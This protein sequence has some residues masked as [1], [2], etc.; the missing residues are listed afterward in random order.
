MHLRR[1]HAHAHTLVKGRVSNSYLP[2]YQIVSQLLPS[3]GNYQKIGPRERTHANQESASSSLSAWPCPRAR[4][5]STKSSF[6]WVTIVGA[7]ENWLICQGFGR[8]GIR[9]TLTHALMRIRDRGRAVLRRG[10][11][12]LHPIGPRTRTRALKE[13]VSNSFGGVAL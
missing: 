7:N 11:R 1:I 9:P 13:R 10:D 5:L 2:I 8:I 4:A 12:E 3:L 6:S